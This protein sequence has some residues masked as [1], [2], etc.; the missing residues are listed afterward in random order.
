VANT[1]SLAVWDEP[2]PVVAGERFA[3]KVGVTAAA[4]KIVEVCDSA[5]KAVASG[6]LGDKPLAGTEALFWTALEIPAPAKN[7]VAVY[8]ARVAGGASAG[9]S[10]VTADK[11]GHTLTVTIAE[12]DSKEPLGG[13]EIRLGPFHAHTGKDGRAELR[14]ASGAYQLQLWRTAHLAQPTP[15]TVDGDKTL[16]LTMLHV[17]E[18]HPDARWVR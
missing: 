7:G 10:V 2:M 13:V 8:T 9:F 1:T 18:E 14:I 17:P 16:S 3:I 6:T 12:Q 5:G 11:P 15:V 4:G